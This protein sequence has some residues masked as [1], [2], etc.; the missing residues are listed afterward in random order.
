MTIA[1]IDKYVE[2]TM[3]TFLMIDYEYYSIKENYEWAESHIRS[4]LYEK[5]GIK[6]G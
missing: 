6:G 1:E 3:T 4:S 2:E 5:Y